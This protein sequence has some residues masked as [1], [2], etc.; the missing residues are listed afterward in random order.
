MYEL[1]MENEN[2]INNNICIE[3]NNY[4]NI[5][6][7]NFCNNF[8]NNIYIQNG[9]YILFISILCYLITQNIFLT[10][11][12]T[13]KLFPANYFYWFHHYYNYNIPK[14]YNFLIQFV[15]FTDIGHVVSF[16]Y[17]FNPSFLP[18]AY[19]IH[20]VITV[21]YWF[22]KMYNLIDMAKLQK[23]DIISWFVNCWTYCI[24]V[25]PFVLLLNEIKQLKSHNNLCYEYFTLQDL[26]YSFSWIYFWLI[27]IYIPWRYIT[28]DPVYTVLS[29]ETPIKTQILFITLIHFL[30][31]FSNFTG[32][33]LF[34]YI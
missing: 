32:Y 23:P 15:R 26:M 21:G 12:I 9:F 22:G 5:F 3:F 13:L 34:Y 33:F 10:T 11:I 6:F 8:F 20:F 1:D 2:K 14:S 19:N 4:C 24:H 31:V 17:F 16:I 28:N 25:L 30:F 29:I 7:N 18:I 27:F